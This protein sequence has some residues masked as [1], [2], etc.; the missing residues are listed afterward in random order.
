MH[1]LRRFAHLKVSVSERAPRAH[2][3]IVSASDRTE[4]NDSL[5]QYSVPV[6]DAKIL[7]MR[8]QARKEWS[9][10]KPW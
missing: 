10:I 4:Q 2:T 3:C 6:T 7:A 9:S 1:D 5:R 8:S